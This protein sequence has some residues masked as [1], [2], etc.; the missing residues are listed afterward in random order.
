M[1]VYNTQQEILGVRSLNLITSEF[2][3]QKKRGL[4]K[5]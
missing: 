5:R 4:D 3:Y 1:V 2:F